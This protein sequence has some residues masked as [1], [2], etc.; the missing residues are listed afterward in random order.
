[1]DTESGSNVLSSPKQWLCHSE[2]SE[3]PLVVKGE[4]LRFTQDDIHQTTLDRTLVNVT[5]L[6]LE[7]SLTCAAPQVQVSGGVL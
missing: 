5:Q 2:R 3:E 4:I 6:R 7:S 1:M